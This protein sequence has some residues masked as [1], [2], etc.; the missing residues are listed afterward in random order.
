MTQ[1]FHNL[2]PAD[3][4]DLAV[5]LLSA[6]LNVRLESFTAGPDGGIDGRHSKGAKSLV[7]QAKHYA[8][9][10]FAALRSR[11][12]KEVKA[13]QKLKPSRYVLATTKGLTPNNK[14]ELFDILKPW[15]RSEADIYGSDDVRGMLRR[16]PIIEKAHIK[17]WLTSSAVLDRICNAA[18]H[19]F[20][21]I[22]KSDIERKVKLYVPNESL[23]Q[24][25]SILETQHVLI[26]SGAPGVGK[27]TLAEMLSYA[28][29]ATGW[30]LIALRRL[31]DGFTAIS[32][33]RKQVFLFDDFLGK[34]AL[35]KRALAH[36]D[37]DLSKFMRKVRNS[38]N[39]RFILTTRAYIFEEARQA[40]EYLAEKSVDVSRYVL[41][42]GVYTRRIRARILYNHLIRTRLAHAY[43]N[44]MAASSELPKIIDHKNY[45]PRIIEWVTEVSHIAD[46]EAVD[47]PASV[48]AALENPKDLWDVAFRTHIDQKCQ[49]LLISL[50]FCG[51]HGEG[52]EKLRAT[53]EELHKGLCGEYG[54]VRSAKDFTESLRT[55]EGSFLSIANGR[56]S[57]LNPSLRDYLGGYLS[58][59]GLI[60][61]IAQH[62]SR[63]ECMSIVW[64][65]GL[66]STVVPEERAAFAKAFLPAAG[67]LLT[68]V[69]WKKQVEPWGF[70]RRRVSIS[71]AERLE[72]LL[73]WWRESKEGAFSDLGCSLAAAPVDGFDAWLDGDEIVQIIYN[74]EHSDEFRSLPGR[75]NLIRLL[76]EGL[77]ALIGS[78][79]AIDDLERM[80]DAIEFT[81]L[82]RPEVTAALEE[83][84]Q[85]EFNSVRE[86]ARSLDSES[87]LEEYSTSL[88]KLGNRTGVLDRR[89]EE[90]KEAIQERIS[91]I[92]CSSESEELPSV[93]CRPKGEQFGDDE[94]RSLFAQLVQTS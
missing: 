26:V 70:S 35:D 92:E 38:P 57:F 28:Y 45:T 3:F 62:T 58:D 66:Q 54:G 5:D 49:H 82:S 78:S 9:S 10:P 12:R 41:N 30:E 74:L 65:H 89:I 75:S 2:S 67:Q 91:E 37:S 1:A 25:K 6:E 61:I 17:L 87:S 56:V 42:V 84:V 68:Q 14:A 71:N 93:S 55:L 33:Q 24:A 11:M 69:V 59:P 46:V 51:E 52:I 4:E 32:D 23:S 7:L 36:K 40:S 8:D 18:A 34:V 76:V 73:Q 50:F 27:T 22:A 20:G 15:L 72:L 16:H 88:E 77:V 64:R 48:L 80:A 43:V 44:A 94:L 31:E 29:G 19:A 21:E 39:A 86:N 63:A 47:Y 90:V 85:L 60:K 83:A 13:I 81:N 79:P 53:F